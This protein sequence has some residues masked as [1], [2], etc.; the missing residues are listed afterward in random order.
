MVGTSLT[1]LC[2]PY[3]F[4][5]ADRAANPGHQSPA[6]GMECILTTSRLLE[7][8]DLLLFPG[9]LPPGE[10]AAAMPPDFSWRP[11]QKGL[12][13]RALQ[14]GFVGERVSAR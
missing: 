8:N 11:A 2:L 6:A 4:S 9:Q 12:G 5:N 1:L 7:F 3:E 14:V 13:V 10:Q